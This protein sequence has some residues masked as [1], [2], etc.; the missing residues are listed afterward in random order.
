MRPA[1]AEEQRAE[2]YRIQRHKRRRAVRDRRRLLR[3][4]G[5]AGRRV[6]ASWRPLLPDPDGDT[7]REENREPA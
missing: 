3:G 7:S 4:S 1:T 6:E 5:E 2:D